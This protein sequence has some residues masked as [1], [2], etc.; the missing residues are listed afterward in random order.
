MPR[1]PRGEAEG[2]EGTGKKKK[3]DQILINVDNL[4]FFLSVMSERSPFCSSSSSLVSQVIAPIGPGMRQKATQRPYG[5]AP[6]EPCPFPIAERKSGKKDGE[7][8]IAQ[9]L[10]Y[11]RRGHWSRGPGTSLGTHWVLARLG[12]TDNG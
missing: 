2:D 8:A 7:P 1:S 6:Q 3:I 12:R 11:Q 5:S 10:W 4:R 9:S